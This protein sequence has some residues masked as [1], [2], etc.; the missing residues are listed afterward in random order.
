MHHILAF[1]L[2]LRFCFM[3]KCTQ[4][5][6]SPYL[7]PIILKRKSSQKFSLFKVFN[8]YIP[9]VWWKWLKCHREGQHLILFL[10]GSSYNPSV[11]KEIAFW[12]ATMSIIFMEMSWENKFF[13]Q[14]DWPS[15]CEKVYPQNV[16]HLIWDLWAHST[17]YALTIHHIS[18]CWP[19]DGLIRP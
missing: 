17:W 5:F 6:F 16:V 10:K 1:Q 2:I 8:S 9:S 19:E 18:E 15:T 3:L 4:Y 7:G 14:F 13:S 12:K 11:H